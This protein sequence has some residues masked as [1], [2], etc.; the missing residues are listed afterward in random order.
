MFVTAEKERVMFIV[1]FLSI[2]CQVVSQRFEARTDWALPD[3]ESSDQPAWVAALSNVVSLVSKSTA[4][5]IEVKV[6]SSRRLL[7]NENVRNE[8]SSL[9]FQSVSCHDFLVATFV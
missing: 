6:A 3:H 4:N 7:G 8:K 2:F 9:Q 1:F 5:K